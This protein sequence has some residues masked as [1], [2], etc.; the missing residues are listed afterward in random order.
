MISTAQHGLSSRPWGRSR[1]RLPPATILAGV[2]A[3]VAVATVVVV[4]DVVVVAAAV[5]VVVAAVAA[6]AVV[7]ADVVVLKCGAMGRR[8]TRSASGSR[9]S[10]PAGTW[11]GRRSWDESYAAGCTQ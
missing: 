9:S 4:I 2:A 1:A 8:T 3:V 5:V 11:Q 7:N 10:P 6:A